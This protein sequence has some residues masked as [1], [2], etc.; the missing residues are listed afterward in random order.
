MIQSHELVVPVE[1]GGERVD[2]WLAK[3]P[4]GLTRSRVQRLIDEG[5]VTIDGK[6]IK[7]NHRLKGEETV[8]VL[9]PPAEPLQTEAEDIP[10][11]IVYEDSD[12]A[13]VNKPA[14]MVT[15]PAQGNYTGTLVNALLHQ[16][17]DLSGINGVMRPGIVHRLDKDTS[18]LLVIAKNDKA[19]LWLADQI[20]G[21]FVKREY[22]ALVHGNLLQDKGTVDAPIARHPSDRKR[23]TVIAG[24]RKAVTHYTVLERFGE[25]CLLHLQ[26][27]T[28]RTHQIRVHMAHINHP[29]VGDP[30]YGPKRAHFG[31]NGQLLH[32]WKLTFKHPRTHQAMSFEAPP[33]RHF[34]TVLQKLRQQK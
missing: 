19:H 15:H 27:E 23:M 14:G 1:A 34:Q 8:A 29:V 6:G 9:I 3:Q 5:H 31:L 30:V 13:V 21:R 20:K 24:G 11:D 7:S 28:G 12:V 18:G 22:Q 17:G 2:S 10:L 16:V 4:I 26:L 32:A 33:P 25:Y